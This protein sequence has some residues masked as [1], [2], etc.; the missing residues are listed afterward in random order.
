MKD[1]FTGIMG[2]IRKIPGFRKMNEVTIEN[3]IRYRGP[4]SYRYIRIIAW[5]IT[6]FFQAYILNLKL[7]IR[8][9]QDVEAGNHFNLYSNLASLV[10]PLFLIAVFAVILN[11]QDK[12]RNMILI[13]SAGSVGIIALYFCVIERYAIRAFR[14]LSDMNRKDAKRAFAELLTGGDE[15]TGHFEFNFLIDI[16]LCVLF[17]YFMMYKPKKCFVGKKLKY[18]RLMALLPI[19]YEVGSNVLKICA[20]LDVIKLP[21]TIFPF[22]TTKPPVMFLMFILLVLI[23]KNR[24]RVFK[25]RGGTEEEYREFLKTRTN[26][27]QFALILAVLLAVFSLLD[28]I[29]FDTLYNICTSKIPNDG[30]IESIIERLEWNLRISS[31]GFGELGNMIWLAPFILLFSYTRQHKNAII[32][33]LIP[34]VATGLIILVGIDFTF[35]VIIDVLKDPSSLLGHYY[36]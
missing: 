6:I 26:S 21:M 25:K 24:E 20:S 36:G 22:L 11:N 28:K 16:L 2:S 32:D 23:L 33:I 27:F 7:R 29:L 18:F 9:G 3:D 10:M 13:Y 30:S 1:F 4:L 5:G 35:D 15:S 12:Y 8:T 14:E 17:L 19:L 34:V 31:W